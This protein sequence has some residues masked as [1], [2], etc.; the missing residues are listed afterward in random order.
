MMSI[1][2]LL[3]DF[4]SSNVK[5]A[6][7]GTT[8]TIVREYSVTRVAAEYLYKTV[9]ALKPHRTVEVGLAWGGSSTAICAALRDNENG[10]RATILDPHQDLPGGP[11]T[12]HGVGLQSLDRYG[13]RNLVD[14]RQ[15]RS[16]WALAHLA[17]D[18]HRIQFAFIDGDHRMDP[19]FV[20]FYFIDRM[21]DV[22][23]VVVFDDFQF[24]AVQ[25][26]VA[27]AMAH[28][29]Y[30]LIACPPTRLAALVKTKEDDRD[31]EQW[32]DHTRGPRAQEALDA[33]RNRKHLP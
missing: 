29:H 22:G 23:G 15:E 10:A 4:Y 9:R 6:A 21:L 3:D 14:F 24:P 28:L 26:V 11:H 31:F 19:T 16:D 25:S 13:L 30:D 17:H 32:Y 18:G 1:D 27:H 8:V 20:D 5:L 7:R 33:L 12:Y 2:Q